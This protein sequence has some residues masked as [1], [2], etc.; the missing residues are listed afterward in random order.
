ML[1]RFNPRFADPVK[2]L[3]VSDDKAG[4]LSIWLD[5]GL[6]YPKDYLKEFLNLNIPYWYLPA[7][8]IDPYS[9]RDYIETGIYKSEYYSFERTEGFPLLH[10]WYDAAAQDKLGSR[11]WPLA[12]FLSISLPIWLLLACCC[13]LVATGR[14]RG[15][16]FCIVAIAFWVTFLFGPVSNFRYVFPLLC[17]YPIA[18][19]SVL[20]PRELFDS[21]L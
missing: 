11:V 21:E 9:Q 1:K 10:A 5:L 15:A 18:I 8:N 4:F 12:P 13:T 7:S 16:L 6:T 3:F 2:R 14:K 19:A 20:R 17:I